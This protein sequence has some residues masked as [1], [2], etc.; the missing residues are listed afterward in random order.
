VPDVRGAAHDAG[1]CDVCGYEP[2]DPRLGIVLADKYV[3]D[4]SIGKG[5]MGAVYRA[6]H[7]DLGEPVAVKF[8]LGDWARTTEIRTR[9]RR[10]AVALAR[11]RHP[12]VVSILDF[13]EHEGDLFLVMELV[14][15]KTLASC[16]KPDDAPMPLLRLGPIFDQL[17]QVL[18]ATHAA[19]LVHRDIKP[20]NVMLTDTGDRTDRVKVL[21]FGLVRLD[22]GND[23]GKLTQTGQVQGTPHYMSPEQCRGVG[24]GSPTDVYAVG[25][26]LYEALAGATPFQAND[27]AIMMAQH[28]F[29]DPPPIASVGY[30]RTVSRG[31]ETVVREAL[32][33]RA[34]DRPTAAELRDRLAAALKGTD[35]V[36]LAA[37][38][39]EDKTRLAGLSR[40][41]RAITGVRR[42]DVAVGVVAAGGDA[43]AGAHESV[44]LWLP[45]GPRALALRDVLSVNGLSP[46]THAGAEAPLDVLRAAPPTLVVVSADSLGEERP[47]ELRSHKPL[48]RTPILVIDAPGA[49][50]ISRLIRAGASDVTLVGAPDDEVLRKIQRLLR[51]GR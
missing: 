38:A 48:A 33:K 44:V 46:V 10:E 39:A 27:I 14:R 9:F 16:M 3:I 21:D 34:D 26:M 8:L 22:D 7:V 18:E 31:L 32:F 25:V 4:E 20:D 30:K 37:R 6:T 43:L 5:G 13:G 40:S 49:A 51:R 15:G 42:A 47:R 36:S 28:M 17:L 24:I 35:P 12:G 11:L 2:V 1:T 45:D 19:K 23:G 50:E 41:D 29:V